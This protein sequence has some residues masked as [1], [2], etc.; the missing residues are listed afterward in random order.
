MID[1]FSPEFFFGLIST[2]LIV[3][4]M[5][6]KTRENILVLKLISD[7]TWILAFLVQGAI[8]GTIAMVF[9][10][11]RTYFGKNHVE[12]KSIGIVLWLCSAILIITFWKGYY[13][14]FSFLGLTFVTVA[15]YLKRP[16]HIKFFFVLASISW[17]FYGYFIG[18][19]EIIIFE[20]FITSAGFLN[21]HL[22]RVSSQRTAKSL[23][24]ES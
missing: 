9:T 3:T 17:G 1:L 6:L 23:P 24:F 21:L 16:G 4:S 14:I 7:V 22:Q 18:Y 13:D 2:I 15:V 10:L 12:I 8:S 11:L 20:F 19:Y 5:F